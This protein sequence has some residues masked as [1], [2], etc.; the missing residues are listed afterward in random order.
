MWDTST[1]DL[2][3]M[4]HG[5]IGSVLDITITYD[6]RSI[7]A[8]SSSNKLYVWD[9]NLGRVCYILTGHMDKLYAVD[10]SSQVVAL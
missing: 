7:I 2:N 6:N 3:N 1:V 4:L 9:A 8:A 5:C 10:V